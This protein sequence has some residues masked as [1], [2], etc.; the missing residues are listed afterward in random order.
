MDLSPAIDPLRGLARPGLFRPVPVDPAGVHG[1]TRQQARSARWRRSSRGLYVFDTPSADAVD[2]RILEAAAVLP[3]YGGVTGWAA[4]RWA[5]AGYLNDTWPSGEPREVTL[6]VVNHDVRSQPGIH[7]TS[8][9]LNPKDLTAVDG[10]PVTR[11]VRSVCF[12]MR[13]A[14]TLGQA[15]KVFDMS[16]LADLVGVREVWA[17]TVSYLSGWTGVERV[18]RAIRLVDENSWSPTETEM[19]LLWTTALLLPRPLCNHPVF[20][21]DGRHI[22]TPDLLDPIAGLVG[23]YDGMLHLEGRRRARDIDREAA[24]RRVGLEYVTMTA[25]DRH[26]P[27]G[28]LRRV[29]EARARARFLPDA[30]RPWTVTPPPWWTPTVTVEQRRGLTQA[31]RARFLGRRT[32]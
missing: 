9:R 29:Q 19:R 31:Q 21:R 24:F 13:Y 32:A 28:Y 5:G 2:Q 4:L 14:A 22:G 6:A 18:R 10:L 26:D 16:A 17:Y 30:E 1:P 20:D 12:E 8:E 27:S 7:V 23:K 15:V 3:P 25:V 11:H